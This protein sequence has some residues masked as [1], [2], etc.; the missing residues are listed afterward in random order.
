MKPRI[1]VLIAD[2]RPR[3]RDGL[4]ALLSCWSTV[5]VVCEASN[6]QEATQFVEESRPDVVLMDMHM[7]KLDGIAATRLIKSRWPHVKVVALSMGYQYRDNA[8]AAG[9]DSFLLKGCPSEQLLEAI[10]DQDKE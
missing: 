3:T 4:R 7:P 10:S 2:D 5:E 6:G 9:A 8:L 1:Q